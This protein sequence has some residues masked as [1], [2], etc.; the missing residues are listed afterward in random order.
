MKTTSYL[1]SVLCL[2]THSCSHHNSEIPEP[3]PKTISLSVD[4]LE[5]AADGNNQTIS[6]V[7]NTEWKVSM[8]NNSDWYANPWYVISSAIEN[9]G[10]ENKWNGVIQIGVTPHYRSTEART[11]KV[12]VTD[13]SGAIIKDIVFTQQGKIVPWFNNIEALYRHNEAKKTITQGIW[14]T[15][16]QREG[17]CMPSTFPDVCMHFPAQREIL[18]YELTTEEQV[19]HDGSL[20]YFYSEIYT[21]LVAVTV[22]D[23]EGFYELALEPGHYSVFVREKELLFACQILFEDRTINPVEIEPSKVTEMGHYFRINYATD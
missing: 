8:Y 13:V 23:D 11:A 19:V 12:F 18:V 9:E 20:R 22:S 7:A 3:P 2:L 15:L 6:V 17:D 21:K 4:S 16:I 1:L 10:Y 14:G 5:F